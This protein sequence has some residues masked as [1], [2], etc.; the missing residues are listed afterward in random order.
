MSL[1]YAVAL[2]LNP[3]FC[4]RYINLYQPRKWRALALAKVKKLWERYREAKI[5]APTT[6][7]FLYEKQNK[8]EAAKPL[9]TY[10]RIK[11]SLE[12]IAKLA[13]KDEYKDYNSQESYDPSI[14]GALAQ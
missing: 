13:N 14:K 12:T 3:I 11:A 6:I 1:F 10:D 9:D 4:I 8:R 2:V 5:L 7:P